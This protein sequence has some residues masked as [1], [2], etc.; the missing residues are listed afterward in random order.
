M[1][2]KKGC[3]FSGNQPLIFGDFSTFELFDFNR[4]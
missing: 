2:S 4:I 1:C 3:M